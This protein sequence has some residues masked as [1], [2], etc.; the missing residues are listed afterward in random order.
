MPFS[1][2]NAPS[3]ILSS[4]IALEVMSPQTFR[5]PQDLAGT[6][7]S[8]AYLNNGLPWEGEGERPRPNYRLYYQVVLGAVDFGKSVNKLLDVY[9]DKRVERPAPQG[10]AILAVVVVDNKGHLVEDPAVAVSSFA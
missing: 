4:W 7:G 2:S 6:F 9:A 3:D 10:E 8:I 5:K 1:F